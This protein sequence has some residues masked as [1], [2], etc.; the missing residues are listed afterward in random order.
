MRVSD[1][2]TVI[3]RIARELQ[4]RYSYSEIDTY[5]AEFG[6]KTPDQISVNSKWVYSKEA[7]SGVPVTKIAEIVEDL[8]MGPAIA[9][10]SALSPPRNWQN[11][12]GIRLFISHIAKDKDKATRLK[13]C[14]EPYAIN[15]FVAHED[16]QPTLEWQREIERALY[17]MDAMVTIHTEGFS[18][19]FWTQQEIGFAIGRGVKVIAFRMGEDPTGFI[20]KQQALL[21]R[22][23]RA[24]GIAR[25]IDALLVED[26]RTRE[27]L[28]A[29]KSKDD[30]IPF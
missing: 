29:A 11:V 1:K 7:L 22:G 25:E 26:E 23:R 8:E 2:L 28:L 20:S 9:L 24:E 30:E 15:G 4:S 16:I 13:T 3:D 18:K 17:C 10:A 14:L 12:E 21:R 5:L 6:V 27:R 19:S